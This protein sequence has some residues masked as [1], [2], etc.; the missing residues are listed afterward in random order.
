MSRNHNYLDK[1]PTEVVCCAGTIVYK[2]I[3]SDPPKR[4]LLEIQRLTHLDPA[5]GALLYKRFKRLAPYGFMT[6]TR[7][8]SSLGLLA[9]LDDS[10]ICKRLFKAFDWL[11]DTLLDFLEWG[12]AI[13]IMMS[14]TADQRLAL[15]YRILKPYKPKPPED[16]EQ[17]W[18]TLY[19]PDYHKSSCF[20]RRQTNTQ[21]PSILPSSLLDIHLDQPDQFITYPEFETI[22]LSLANTRHQLIGGLIGDKTSFVNSP[23]STEP[24]SP[25]VIKAVFASIAKT[26]TASP[27]RMSLEE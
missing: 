21:S 8:K 1:K 10:F 26:N 4:L 25:E 7:F 15:S 18:Q 24:F 11:N 12:S 6:Y 17:R 23:S 2:L 5:T 20:A 22:V 13:A 27:Y 9:L 16:F 19:L 14:G 3:P